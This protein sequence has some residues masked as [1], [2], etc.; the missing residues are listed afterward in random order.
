MPLIIRF[1]VF[2]P[3]WSVTGLG[4]IKGDQDLLFKLAGMAGVWLLK[5]LNSSDEVK[6]L[7]TKPPIFGDTQEVK[8]TGPI[9][10]FASTRIVGEPPATSHPAHSP[11]TPPSACGSLRLAFRPWL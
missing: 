10:G 11:P 6:I 3:D 2:K 8:T 5:F 9:P 4:T 7:V 1:E